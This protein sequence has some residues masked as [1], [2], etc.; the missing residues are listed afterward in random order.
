MV[1][2]KIKKL[3]TS[4]LCSYKSDN[5][6]IKCCDGIEFWDIIQNWNL[7]SIFKIAKCCC[8]LI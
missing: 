8:V 3:K 5:L 4:I 2:R 6:L 7:S 1:I